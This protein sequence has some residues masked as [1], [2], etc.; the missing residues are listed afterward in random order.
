M[1]TRPSPVGFLMV[2]PKP[3]TVQVGRAVSRPVTLA[4][5]FDEFCDRPGVRTSVGTIRS[6]SLPTLTFFALAPGEA[7]AL[8]CGCRLLA[9]P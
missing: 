8:G 4:R 2:G 9:F 1:A 5:A 7:R 6:G 3:P